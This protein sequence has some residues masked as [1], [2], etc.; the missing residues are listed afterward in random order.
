MGIPVFCALLLTAAAA[1]F[2]VRYQKIPNILALCGWIVG[3]GLWM[4]FRGFRG[5]SVWGMGTVVTGLAAFAVYKIGGIGAG[6]VKLLS[7]LGSILSYKR[8]LWVFFAAGI[9]SV[10]VSA[11]RSACKGELDQMIRRSCEILRRLVA[12]D[13]RRP[14]KEQTR[15]CFAVMLFGG[16]CLRALQE[17]WWLH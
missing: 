8:G 17:W 10:V 2:D 6:D 9:L 14:E 7:A 13:W 3:A 11:G 16:V 1:Y 12:G 5:L 15:V 4:G